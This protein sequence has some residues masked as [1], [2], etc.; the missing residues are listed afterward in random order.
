MLPKISIIVST[1]YATDNS[2]IQTLDS[3]ILQAFT[4][5]EIIVISDDSSAN[6]IKTVDSYRHKDERIKCVSKDNNSVGCAQ[7]VGLNVAAGEYVLFCSAGD[8]I[9]ENALSTMYHRAR[10]RMADLVIGMQ[11]IHYMEEVFIPEASRELAEKKD[12]DK[13]DF[14]LNQNLILENK[15]FKSSVIEEH[16][17]QFNSTKNG[18]DAVFVFS[19]IHGCKRITGCPKVVYIQNKK[20]FWHKFSTDQ[21]YDLNSLNNAEKNF[22]EIAEIADKSIAAEEERL[23]SS[24]Y[25]QML[26]IERRNMHE[27]Y[28]SDLYRNFISLT[29]LNEYYRYIWKLTEPVLQKLKTLLDKYK[30][31]LFPT[32]WK[33]IIDEHPDLRL[34]N[35]MMSKEELC[36]QPLLSILIT[37]NVNKARVSDILQ[38]FYNQSFPAFE[39]YLDSTLKA[40]VPDALKECPNFHYITHEIFSESFHRNALQMFNAP[41][42][43]FVEEDVIPSE[44]TIRQ[45]MLEIGNYTFISAPVLHMNINNETFHPLITQ[46]TVYVNDLNIVRLRSAYNQLDWLSGNKI[47]NVKVLR[48]RIILFSDNYVHDI[49]RLY[50]NAKYIKTTTTHFF[51]TLTDKDILRNTK[52][53]R[54]RIGYKYKNRQELKR[55]QRIEKENTRITTIKQKFL[56]MRERNMRKWYKAL[57]VK[58]LYPLQYKRMSR[59]PIDKSKVVIIV[60]TQKKL[61]SATQH[62]ADVLQKEGYD[63][64]VQC[65]LRLS[66]RFR[67]KFKTTM[68]LIA[69]IATAKAIFMD[70]ANVEI[71]R[72]KFRP[73]T[74][75]VQLWHGCGAFK[76]FGY[77]TVDKI[78][79][80]DKKQQ[81]MYPPHQIYDLVTV[82]SPEVIWAYE[83]AMQ[84]EGQNKVKAT[85]ISRT[86]VFFDK[87]YIN[88]ARER[89]YNLVP[90]ARSKKVILYAPTF[91]GRVARATGPSRLDF[92][93][94]FQSLSE[95]YILLIKHHPLVKKLP[96]IPTQYKNSFVFD[97]TRT[98]DIEDLICTADICISDYSSLIFEYSLFEKPMIL[99]A[100][101]LDTYFDWRGFYYDYFDMAPGPVL[102][103]TEEIIDYIVHLDERFDKE[104]VIRFREKFMASCDGHSTERILKEAGLNKQPVSL[105]IPS[106]VGDT[107]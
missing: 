96:E 22:R 62:M 97:V 52:G 21:I 65:L 63:V 67:D 20:P 59:K 50:R 76:K 34:Q 30:L 2:V 12:I 101:D 28:R 107:N 73:E 71:S 48:S 68:S 89:I 16:G 6:T 80:G 60:S 37:D 75:V 55:I 51:T 45:M 104:K 41:H 79:G 33:S 39:I 106:V 66:L 95:E 86:D 35:G 61:T 11:E 77:S 94:L 13:F 99:F 7:N 44:H 82:S 78:F 25:S 57:T 90:T 83:E 72:I 26:R 98:A 85:G 29:L 17:L 38:S 10:T 3:I 19:F 92:E 14:I 1:S 15:L 8:Y 69:D 40:F 23:S 105:K 42:A 5:F 18:A 74:C 49:N 102:F 93:Q 24:D 103:S 47:F 36:K 31:N 87:T 56:H 81:D 64:H 88:K 58:Y 84:L 4:D 70:E 32:A 53:F 43:L 100:Y 46:N 54:V 27:R 91:R 9:P